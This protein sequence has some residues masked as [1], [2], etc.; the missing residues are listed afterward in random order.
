V[1]FTQNE[2][3]STERQKKNNKKMSSLTVFFIFLPICVL[4][5]EKC[6]SQVCFLFSTLLNAH[7]LKNK[8]KTAGDHTFLPFGIASAVLGQTDPKQIFLVCVD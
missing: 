7:W 4:G 1:R 6:S 2:L 5:N 3:C 8:I